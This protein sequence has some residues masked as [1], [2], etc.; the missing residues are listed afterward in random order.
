MQFDSPAIDINSHSWATWRSRPT[1]HGNAKSTELMYIRAWN[2]S[3]TWK[4]WS[5]RFQVQRTLFGLVCRTFYYLAKRSLRYISSQHLL[6]DK[7]LQLPRCKGKWYLGSASMPRCRY[8]YCIR[9]N[10]FNA[11][12]AMYLGIAHQSQ[13]GILSNRRENGCG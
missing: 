6:M 8:N 13:L 11:A 2:A 5:L 3:R 12:K 4:C 1:L 7:L 10:P 9:E